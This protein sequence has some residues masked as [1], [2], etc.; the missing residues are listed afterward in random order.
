MIKHDYPNKLSL[1]MICKNEEKNV[2]ACLDSFIP[3]ADEILICDTGSTD[4]TM[5]E[6]ARYDGIVRLIRTKWQQDFSKARNTC[7]KFASYGW[8]M[9]AD[10]DDRLPPESI[11]IIQKIKTRP[12]DSY[13][14]F[15]VIN[16][17][18]G[19]PVGGNFLQCRMWPNSSKIYFENPLHEKI[20][21]SCK[22]RGLKSLAIQQ[23]KI[24]HTG[25]EN[26]EMKKAKAKRNISIIETIADYNLNPYWLTHMGI[27]YE[28]LGDH[29]TAFDY[30][31]NVLAIE[32]TAEIYSKLGSSK[33]FLKEYDKAEK[34]FKLGLGIDS[35]NMKM[36]YQL[37]KTYEFSTQFEKAVKYYE[38]VLELP[39]QNETSLSYYDNCR[40][41]TFHFLLRIYSAFG[42]TKRA[43]EL[44]QEM[45]LYYPK[46]RADD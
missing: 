18:K 16:T 38:R 10:F 21:P 27:N 15:N 1:V 3:I 33:L 19:L 11:P 6:V 34:Y 32:E 2:K 17:E 22:K 41:Y 45:N 26:Q 30:F 44:V 12:L 20:A 42:I 24:Y 5:K 25:Y 35:S 28:M 31:F 14:Y 8:I 9:W 13:Y 4:N 36:T 46:H 39:R 29:K 43:I 37:A 40:I 7:M 23:V